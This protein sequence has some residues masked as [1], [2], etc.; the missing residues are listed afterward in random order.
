[1][2]S[3]CCSKDPSTKELRPTPDIALITRSFLIRPDAAKLETSSA[4]DLPVQRQ[5][6]LR[7]DE[8]SLA[9]KLA[10]RNRFCSIIILD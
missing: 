9:L 8:D 5:A 7:E 2:K 1:M 10:C 3:I 4:F 6:I